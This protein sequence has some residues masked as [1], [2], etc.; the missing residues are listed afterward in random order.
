MK[1]AL[2][3]LIVVAA[4]IVPST[5]L[6]AEYHCQFLQESGS[7]FPLVF[8]DFDNIRGDALMGG[9]ANKGRVDM[10][11][12]SDAVTF[13]EKTRPGGATTTT[14]IRGGHPPY[15]A[16]HSRNTVIFG[17]LGP[18]QMVGECVIK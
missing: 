10:F 5:A 9:N 12:G 6:A 17:Q 2:K 4:L 16:V 7:P 14:I 3:A 11:I 1:A 13:I 8:S 18:E 15:A